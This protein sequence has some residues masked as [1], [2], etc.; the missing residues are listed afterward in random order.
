MNNETEAKI[1]RVCQHLVSREIIYCVSSLVWEMTQRDANCDDEDLRNLW[2]RESWKDALQ[3]SDATIVT[4]DHYEYYL[5]GETERFVARVNLPGC[6]PDSVA[7]F[8]DAESAWE[9]LSDRFRDWVDSQEYAE[10]PRTQEEW[11]SFCSFGRDM[12]KQDGPGTMY[13]PDN[14]VYVVDTVGIEIIDG[15]D[16]MEFSDLFSDAIELNSPEAYREACEEHG[17]EDPEN[18]EAMEHWI[19]SD[20]MAR[21]LEEHGEIVGEWCGLTI[22]GRCCSGQSIALDCVIREIA[23]EMGI[24]PG[25]PNAWE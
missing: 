3:E 4:H 15:L 12:G 25:Q 18:S 13:G 19:V 24:L 8:V 11:N 21:R 9:Y 23:A 7:Y 6:M 5:P 14:M 10:E 2:Y 1:E 20:F 17:I 16:D 22:W